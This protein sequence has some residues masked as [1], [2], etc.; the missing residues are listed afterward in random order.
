M[1]VISLKCPNCDGDLRFDPATQ[2]YKC[3]YCASLFA[4]GELPFEEEKEAPKKEAETQ[5]TH[6]KEAEDGVVYQC[7]SCGAEIVT[8]QNTAATFCYYCHNPVV[9]Q[10]RLSGDLL[11]SKVIPFQI[12]KDQAEEGFLKF[13]NEK[14]FVPKNFFQKK[15]IEKMTGVYFP[16]W[17]LD[18]D[19]EGSIQAEAKN[20]RVWVSGDTQ[21]REEKIYRVER[22]G[23]MSFQ[24]ITR[25]AL[26]KANGQLASGVLPYRFEDQKDFSFGY[27][28]G[29]YAE[30]RDVEQKEVE[31]EMIE[32][33][34]RS[35]EKLLL[36]EVSG[37]DSVQ[38]QHR[39]LR[40]KKTVYDY[41]LLPVWTIT[42]RGSDNEM[43]YYSMNGQTGKVSGRLPLDMPKLIRVS[44]LAA[45]VAF[46]FGF[47]GGYL[48]W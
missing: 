15:Q 37:Y 48:L 40:A 14:K 7:P 11:P 24:D 27:L 36:E 22:E 34:Y 3:E 41:M 20:E 26:K 43:Y 35:G 25:S 5:K 42:Y 28:S 45:V 46:I 38:V 30:K 6:T 29:F 21:F 47:V 23:T 17:V 12:T 2:K 4:E 32:E 9:L 31:Q 1:S 10:G 18:A 8:D 19:V 44:L 16:Y 13:V 33:A 39:N